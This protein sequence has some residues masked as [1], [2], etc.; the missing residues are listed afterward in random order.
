MSTKTSWPA[1]GALK[2]IKGLTEAAEKRNNNPGKIL[3]LIYQQMKAAAQGGNR[4]ASFNFNNRRDWEVAVT[5]QSNSTFESCVEKLREEGFNVY[6]EEGEGADPR[7]FTVSWPGEN[8]PTE[9]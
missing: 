9:Q 4:K 2:E 8:T 6:A 1:T 7:I 5:L 3:G